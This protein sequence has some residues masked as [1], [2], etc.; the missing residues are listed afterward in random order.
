MWLKYDKIH[1]KKRNLTFCNCHLDK[2]KNE[3]ILK[4]NDLK[5]FNRLQMREILIVR[6]GFKADF[7]AF[8][9]T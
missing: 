7:L 6:K 9:A 1:L 2:S 5:W 8:K 4:R 3:S